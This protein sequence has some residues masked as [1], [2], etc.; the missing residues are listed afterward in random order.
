MLFF[1]GSAFTAES[2]TYEYHGVALYDQAEGRF[3]VKDTLYPGPADR[4]FSYGPKNNNWIPVAGDWNGNGIYGVALYDQKEGIFLVKDDS[5]PGWA[6]REFRYGPKNN[7]WIPVAGDWTGDGKGY[8]V[9]LYDQ[10][11]GIFLVKD[12]SQP[13]WA[14]REFRYGPTN[15]NFIPVAGDWTGNGEFGVAL[16]DQQKGEFLV[17]DDSQPGWADHVFSF[18]PKNNNWIPVAGLWDRINIKDGIWYGVRDGTNLVHLYINV[19]DN[20]ISR[21][22]S[23]LPQTR[24]M[25][26]AF[27]YSDYTMWRYLYAEIPISADGTFNHADGSIW[28][29]GG[30]I[31]VSGTFSSDHE[32]YE[33][34]IS[35]GF[36]SHQEDSSQTRRSMSYNWTGYHE[37]DVTITS[38]LDENDETLY[39][40]EFE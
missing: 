6:D 16:Y 13:G 12:D 37:D 17:K 25:E 4:N 34:I 18:G 29:I 28:S 14:D 22:N 31:T 38:T 40:V 36:A 39:I 32:Q 11:K 10:N 3:H 7:N 9:A 8:G 5:Q 27:P 1:V 35:S 15:N 19:N 20:T 2:A 21:V 23:T 33:Q 30:R 24:S 26:V